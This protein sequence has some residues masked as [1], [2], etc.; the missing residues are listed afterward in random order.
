MTTRRL[1]LWVLAWLGACERA[2][3]QVFVTHGERVA[4]DS[5]RQHIQQELGFRAHAPE[6]DEVHAV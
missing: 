4:A 1:H 3:K 5:L 2:P 6:H